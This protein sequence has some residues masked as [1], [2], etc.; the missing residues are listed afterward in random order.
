[1]FVNYDREF[2]V[3]TL[4]GAENGLTDNQ[5]TRLAR[6]IERWAKEHG[7]QEISAVHETLDDWIDDRT[8]RGRRV[9]RAEYRAEDRTDIVDLI[10]DPKA[11]NPADVFVVDP[12]QNPQVLTQ[13]DIRKFAEEFLEGEQSELILSLFKQPLSLNPDS[14][15]AIR[16][17]LAIIRPRVREGRLLVPKIVVDI[18]IENGNLKIK[19]RQGYSDEKINRALE[20][21]SQ[22]LSPYQ[23]GPRIGIKRCTV[24]WWLYR[25]MGLPTPRQLKRAKA[26][27]LYDDEKRP[28]EIA[29][30]TGLTPSSVY[31]IL[32]G[33]RGVTFDTFGED[34]FVYES[35]TKSDLEI[36]PPGF[37]DITAYRKI[38]NYIRETEERYGRGPT[39]AEMCE[40]FGSNPHH[41]LDN[42]IGMGILAKR[43]F[44]KEK[45]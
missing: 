35:C 23:I 39:H 3:R 4:L 20:L 34:P 28:P 16:E 5:K 29:R 32:K 1:M 6:D 37:S 41:R 33:E 21:Y 10:T 30:L 13:D 38:L 43:K 42:M 8:K 26:L 11:K 15:E 14:P 27:A 18:R 45:L 44:P 12:R 25:R 17:K 24:D 36:L 19:Y 7:I 40:T 2:Y 22:G 9:L 31:Q